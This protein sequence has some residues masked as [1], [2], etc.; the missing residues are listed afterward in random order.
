MMFARF[1][2]WPMDDLM[3]LFKDDSPMVADVQGFFQ[4]KILFFSASQQEHLFLRI[5]ELLL[6]LRLSE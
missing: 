1:F 3:T 2:F 4:V 6:T 5:S